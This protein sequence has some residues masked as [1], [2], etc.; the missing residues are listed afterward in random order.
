MNFSVR[1]ERAVDFR[2]LAYGAAH[3]CDI[4]FRDVMESLAPQN[5]A[6]GDPYQKKPMRN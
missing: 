3:N 1:P 4:V 6:F 2:A 5:P